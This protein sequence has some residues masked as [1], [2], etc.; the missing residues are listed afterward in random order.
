[1]MSAGLGLKGHYQT[2][3]VAHPASSEQ[4]RFNATLHARAF[5]RVAQS[6][7]GGKVALGALALAVVLMGALSATL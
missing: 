3:Q 5:D 2:R 1:M 7:G 4:R 6:V